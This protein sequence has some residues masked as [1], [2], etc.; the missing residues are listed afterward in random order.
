[1]KSREKKK[2]PRSTFRPFEI[3]LFQQPISRL[4][5]ADKQVELHNTIIYII[6]VVIIPSPHLETGKER[7]IPSCKRGNDDCGVSSTNHRG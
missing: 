4:F 3:A 5:F 2:D 7:K 6:R 1:M